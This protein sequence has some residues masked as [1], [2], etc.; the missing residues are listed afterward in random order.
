[1]GRVVINSMKTGFIILI[2]VFVVAVWTICIVEILKIKKKNNR[3]IAKQ[4]EEERKKSEQL[5]VLQNI[6]SQRIQF[7]DDFKKEYGIPFKVFR[8]SI[9]GK[10]YLSKELLTKNNIFKVQTYYAFSRFKLKNS[11]YFFCIKHYYTNIEELKTGNDD[12]LPKHFFDLTPIE[13]VIL[14]DFEDNEYLENLK[15][16]TLDDFKKSIYEYTN[17]ISVKYLNN[18]WSTTSTIGRSPSGLELAAANEFIGPGYAVGMILDSQKSI[19]SNYDC[20]CYVFSF[21]EKLHIENGRLY[22]GADMALNSRQLRN[23]VEQSED[24]KIIDESNLK[25]TI[26]ESDMKEL[27]LLKELYE[28]N[29]LT[30]V[31]YEKQTEQI[32]K[33]YK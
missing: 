5:V 8:D 23:I 1:M 31:E 9:K 7:L 22:V 19:T 25:N 20:S 21:S 2:I 26:N 29:C 18:K 30:T 33:K 14:S 13:K 11:Q 6:Q 28:L 15:K 12:F 24:A 3:I 32:L 4:K 27:S 16:C 10:F 17:L